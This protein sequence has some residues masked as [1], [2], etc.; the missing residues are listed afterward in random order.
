MI[1]GIGIDIVELNR[2]EQILQKQPR[3]LSRILSQ[4][5]QLLYEQMETP[6]RK[7]EFLAGRFAAKEAFS[8]AYGT[9]IG[10]V[11]FQEIEVLKTEA[12]APVVDIDR[13]AEEK[14]WVS[15]S[16]SDTY[17]VAQVII[18]TDSAY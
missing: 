16:H 11:S 3:F 13:L 8:K 18:E 12:G 14:V 15:I 10:P 4:R 17:A 6:K 2:I 5:E 7:V 9:G 1:I